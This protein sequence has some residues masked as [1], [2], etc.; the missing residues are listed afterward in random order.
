MSDPTQVV[1]ESRHGRTESGGDH[2]QAVEP[3][4]RV[5]PRLGLALAAAAVM[6]TAGLVV[7]TADDPSEDSGLDTRSTLPSPIASQNA[8]AVDRDAVARST[9]SSIGLIHWTVAS[10][11]RSTLPAAVVRR[12]DSGLVG[13]DDVGDSVWTSN[14]GT[15]WYLGDEAATTEVG[16]RR[17]STVRDDG[18][19][20]LVEVTDAG[21]VPTRVTTHTQGRNGVVVAW[22]VPDEQP[23]VVEIDGDVFARLDRREEVPWRTVLAIGPSESYRVRITD[24]AN[25]MLAESSGKTAPE[26]VELS[27]RLDGGQAVLDDSTGVAVWNVEASPQVASPLDAVRPRLTTEWLLWNGRELESIEHPWASTDRVDVARI[28]DAL[29]AVATISRDGD[30]RVWSTPDGV[31]WAPVE[32]P[33][34]PSP[35]SPIPV[36]AS[37]DQAILTISDG[38]TTSHWS[39]TNAVTF[40]RLV[41][42]PGISNRSQGSF[43]WIAPDPRS[44][45]RL[46]VS[47]DGIAWEVLDLSDQLG[48]DFSRWDTH[49]DAVAIGS[50][51]HVVATRGTEHTLLV[52][53]VVPS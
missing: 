53:T 36:A 25:E 45:P 3:S 34:Q 6:V 43:G 38:T 13:R 46:Q 22:E 9:E 50:S 32:L 37:D 14:D 23:G 8:A 10:G 5:G 52:G 24:G 44:L 49:I 28:D 33:I 42:V 4:R 29:I 51:I 26:T 31:R 17:W 39:T 30:T 16:G 41:D 7:R 19:R 35:G 20:R 2:E 21:R 18:R 1:D 15:A 48:F 40:E 11:D 12:A 47:P 27:V